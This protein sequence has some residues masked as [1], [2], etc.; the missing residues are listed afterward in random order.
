MALIKF[1]KRL[2]LKHTVLNS[3]TH[4]ASIPCFMCRCL[5]NGGQARCNPSQEKSSSKTQTVRSTLTSRR[6]YVGDG[7][8]R[9]G[10]DRESFSSCG[11]GILLRMQSGSPRRF[12]A[13]RTHFKK[14]SRPTEFQRS[15]SRSFVS[16]GRNF[17]HG[18]STCGNFG[19]VHWG[20]HGHW[21]GIGVVLVPAGHRPRP[22]LLPWAD[23]SWV[24][25]S[26][27][28]RTHL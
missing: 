25:V 21:L 6:F 26:C 4:G 27:L 15:S 11:R 22:V 14:T 9:P 5:S 18:G 3:L 28:A 1:W 10:D 2:G 17:L 16:V 24:P 7:H 19:S 12:L 8:P 13:T 23:Y 20:C